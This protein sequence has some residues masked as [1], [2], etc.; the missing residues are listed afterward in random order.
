ML[1]AR[2]DAISFSHGTQRIFEGLN[3]TLNDGEKIGLVGPNGAGKSTLLRLL[4]GEEQPNAGAIVLRGGI[5][6]AYLPQ[7]YAEG[8]TTS[9]IAEVL[10]G[11]GDLLAIE[12]ELDA[13]ER[14]LADPA[15]ASD[16]DAIGQLI[17]RQAALLEWYEEGGGTRFRS[18]ARELLIRLGL[19][20]ADHE[21]SLALLSGGQR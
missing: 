2:L 19:P 17:E 21:R 9:A 10:D 12:A 3:L 5:R 18:D 16:M 13:V 11:R 14:A 8:T 20:A 7:E 4:A 1:I 15:N 6:A